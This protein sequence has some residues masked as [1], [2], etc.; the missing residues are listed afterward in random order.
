MSF[1]PLSADDKPSVL[2]RAE[3]RANTSFNRGYLCARKS[4]YGGAP[5]GHEFDAHLS[6][7]RQPTRF[8]SFFSSW[9][10]AMKRRESLEQN[11]EEDIVVIA[12][13]AK[14]LPGV[15]SAEEVAS[16]LG[17]S[18]T[19]PNP[20]KRLCNHYDEYLVEGGIAMDE[21]RILALFEGG[22]PDRDVVPKVSDKDCGFLKPKIEDHALFP[23]IEGAGTQTD[24]SERLRVVDTPIPALDTFFQDVR[25]L[26]VARK[27]MQT[28]LQPSEPWESKNKVTI[29]EELGGH[30]RMAG[31]ASL[32]ERKR[33]TNIA[34]YSRIFA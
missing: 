9:R 14:D 34:E 5:A 2:F 6:W 4:I 26:S 8:L 22:G 11:G 20:R 3:C 17:Y 31:H 21:Y 24:I 12:V 27:K 25:F 33:R 7:K 1:S 23:T 13:W 10:R 16:I 32:G 19:G 18:N 29:D 30:Y 15:Y 28:L